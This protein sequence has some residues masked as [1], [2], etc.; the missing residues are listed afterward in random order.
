LVVLLALLRV[1]EHLVGLVDVLE[2]LLGL[3]VVRVEVGVELAGELAVGGANLLLGG[4]LLHAENL[5]VVL[6]LH[7]DVKPLRLAWRPTS[8]RETRPRRCR[9]CPGRPRRPRRS[10]PRLAARRPRPGP[11][12]RPGRPAGASG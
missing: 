11:G 3:L 2:A 10:A 7:L 5:V 12:R 8:P 9:S 6:E 4:G 1:R